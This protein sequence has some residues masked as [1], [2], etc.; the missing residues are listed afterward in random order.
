MPEFPWGSSLRCAGVL[1]AGAL[2]AGCAAKP[3]RRPALIAVVDSPN[4]IDRLF[5][6]VAWN[7][8]HYGPDAFVSAAR[9][10]GVDLLV[11][12]HPEPRGQRCTAALAG[13]L[14]ISARKSTADGARIPTSSLPVRRACDIGEAGRAVDASYFRHRVARRGNEVV[15]D[16]GAASSPAAAVNA[17]RRMRARTLVAAPG[18]AEDLL[19]FDAIAREA[20]VTLY[21][22][23]ADGEP[24]ATAVRASLMLD[25]ACGAAR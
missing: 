7:D 8:E 23:Q 2:L 4:A 24:Q 11:L 16:D 22:I 12:E 21:E 19:C 14:R 5:R 10:A 18:S 9:R 1:L 15:I 20:E 6:Y 17:L 25:Q 13:A 3:A